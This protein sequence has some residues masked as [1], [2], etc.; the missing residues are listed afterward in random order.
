MPELDGLL[1]VAIRWTHV[2]AM[3]VVLGGAALLWVLSI[4]AE[5][6]AARAVTWAA[7][8]YEH[9]FWAAVGVLVMTGVG[10][11]AAFGMQL[12]SAGGEWGTAMLSKL[13]L[14]LALATLSVPRTLAV[15]RVAGA[16]DVADVGF[17]WLYGATTLAVLVILALAV[18][19]SHG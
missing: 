17:G 12:P 10:N 4:R 15:A 14:V 19:A 6:T 16:G 9:A 7:V 3:A 13:I 5:P 2:V 11:L 8:R 18:W 1:S